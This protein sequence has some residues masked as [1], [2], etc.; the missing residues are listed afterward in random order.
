MTNSRSL[1]EAVA[2]VL[3]AA[4]LA[5]VAVAAVGTLVVLDGAVAGPAAIAV[6]LLTA[7]L[8]RRPVGVAMGRLVDR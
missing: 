8:L 4:L 1:R 2:I 7:Q 3:F 6:A 5:V